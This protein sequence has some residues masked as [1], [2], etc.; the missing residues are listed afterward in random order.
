MNSEREPLDESIQWYTLAEAIP[1]VVWVARPDGH[2]FYF[3]GRWYDYT[4]LSREQSIGP[5]WSI[6]L[7]PDDR[8]RSVARWEQATGTGEPYEVEY[9]LRAADGSYRW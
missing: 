1:Q 9:R 2:P 4:G 6:P 7:H 8:E 5:G 3:N